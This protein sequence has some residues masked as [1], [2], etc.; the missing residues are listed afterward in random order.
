M[1]NRSA[2]PKVYSVFFVAVVLSMMIAQ[3]FVPG[4]T[5][6][7]ISVDYLWRKDLIKLFNGFKYQ[8]G[9]RVFPQSVVGKDGWLYYTAE[10]SMQDYQKVSPLNMGN[11]KRLTKI[12]EKIKH[13]TEQYGGVFFVVIPPDKSTVY[14][15]YMPDEIPVIGQISSLDRLM[16]YLDEN[17]D[18][19][20]LDL[21]PIFSTLGKNTQLYY[22]TDTHW[23]CQGAFYA[24]NEILSIISDS[25]PQIQPYAPDDFE[26]SPSTPS[27]RDIS[28]MMG[29]D[30][31]EDFI[32]P[33]P[34]SDL[35]IPKLTMEN[36]NDKIPSLRVSVNEQTDLPS[37]V[38]F[39]DSFYEC[40]DVFVEPKFSSTMSMHFKDAELNDY[41]DII[42][43]EKP[44][45]VIVEFVE[46]S[47]DFFYRHLNN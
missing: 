45:V 37:L 24:S 44:D 38:V 12:L 36:T 9:D 17:S 14:P 15:Q 6:E 35:H 7:S 5:L 27:V 13:Q 41:L 18:V 23:N 33:I 28:S 4:M 30:L 39:R 16:D 8:I 19:Q 40:M 47:M 1:K 31:R 34:K 43:A 29:I 20:V 22:K 42:A 25:Y 10:L 2:W 32:N 3:L 26:F 11:T 46:R 21:R